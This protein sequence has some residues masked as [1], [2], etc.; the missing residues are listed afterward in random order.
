[1]QS[2]NR[3]VGDTAVIGYF[4]QHPPEVDPSLR[5][6]DYIREVA[7]KR[8]SRAGESGLSGLPDTPEVLLEKLGF[9]RKIQ[10]QKVESLS[11]GERRRLHLAAVLAS[12]PNVLILDEPTNDLD[13]NTVEVLEDMLQAYQG[14][15]LVVSHDR[16]FMEGA[17][18]ELLVM[19]GDGNVKRF[20]G[21]YSDY[22]KQLAQ[23]RQQQAAAAVE[24]QKR[25]K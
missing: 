14:L 12:A 3:E 11:G 9:P 5:L 7:D 6:I 24:L 2:G 22:L 21:T 23:L 17:T 20:M 13:L 15:L 4:Q 18:S 1:M 25:I 16:A 10:F 19:A 8:K